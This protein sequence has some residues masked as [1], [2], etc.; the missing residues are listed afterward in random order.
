VRA[1]QLSSL[2]TGGDIAAVAVTGTESRPRES[3][4]V[5]VVVLRGRARG[6]VKSKPSKGTYGTHGREAP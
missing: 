4:A 5:A 3:E 1:C 2:V 6:E